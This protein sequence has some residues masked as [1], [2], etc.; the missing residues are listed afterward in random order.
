MITAQP[1][2]RSERKTLSWFIKTLVVTGC[3]AGYSP[4]APATAGSAVA[5]LMYWFLPVFTW[6]IW[7]VAVISLGLIG[8]PLA[9]WGEKRWGEDPGP[10][11]IDEMLGY[12]IAVAF[13]PKT[14]MTIVLG[15]FVFRVFDIIKPSPGR[16]LEKLPG[17]W[18]VMADDVLAGIYSNVLLRLVFMI[19]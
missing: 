4:I 13:L 1:E 18:G 17:G 15:F 8:V 14:L 10:V 9:T 19:L 16:R 6:P 7:L 12:L 2:S 3:F 5:A 11:V